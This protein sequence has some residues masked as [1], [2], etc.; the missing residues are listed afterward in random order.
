[1]Q[2]AGLRENGGNEKKRDACK[3]LTCTK[4]ECVRHIYNR[5]N[6]H[7][8]IFESAHTSQS[9]MGSS[10]APVR[11]DAGTA[12]GKSE[13]RWKAHVRA[14]RIWVGDETWGALDQ[15][16]EDQRNEVVRTLARTIFL[17]FFLNVFIIFS[18][19]GFS[20]GQ[21]A[22]C[23]LSANGYFP[24]LFPSPTYVGIFLPRLILV[25]PRLVPVHSVEQAALAR[26]AWQL[27]Q[28]TCVQGASTVIR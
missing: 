15:R 1:M 14:V 3:T 10:S 18:Y 21:H 25:L 26:L 22:V 16:C 6:A 23:K 19:C 27:P 5:E 2:E 24:R 8:R 11:G 17:R 13:S 20:A 7:A 12:G 9:A 4:T 28:L